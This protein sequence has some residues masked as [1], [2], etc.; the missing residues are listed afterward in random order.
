MKTKKNT[1]T[2]SLK[3]Q[4]R[5]RMAKYTKKI[6]TVPEL[7]LCGKWLAELGFTEENRVSVHTSKGLIII[8]PEQA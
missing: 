6:S 7:K 1:K 4:S 3:I 8:Q 5:Y 2:R